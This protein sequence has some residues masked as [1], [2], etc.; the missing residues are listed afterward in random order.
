[1][2]FGFSPK[3][4][5]IIQ[6]FVEAVNGKVDELGFKIGDKHR[7]DVL[8]SIEHHLRFLSIKHAKRSGSKTVEERD[9][10]KILKRMSPTSVCRHGLRNPKTS[11]YTE[12]LK[13]KYFRMVEQKLTSS[14][15]PLVLDA[16]CG[17]GRQLMEYKRWGLDGEFVG[18]DIDRDAILYANSAEPSMH[19]IRAD[20]QGALPFTGN[21]FDAVVC[22]GVLHETTQYLGIQRAIQDF[23]WVLK[24]RGLLYLVDAFARNRIISGMSHFVW[25]IAPKIGRYL[26]TS[27]T[28]NILK[29]N[30]FIRISMEKAF[31]ITVPLIDTYSCA[32]IVRKSRRT[33]TSDIQLV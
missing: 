1:M 3:A 24:P 7:E 27:Y 8:S 9:V 26:H 29:Q 20:V 28:R 17:Y 13:E 32:A 6:A 19:F 11:K 10:K 12:K 30:R 5:K 31:I 22:I 18:V 21:K 2:P 23:A 15:E 33:K 16:G 25:K 4:E 14:E